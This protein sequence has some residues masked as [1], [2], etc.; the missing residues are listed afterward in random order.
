MICTG[1]FGWQWALVVRRRLMLRSLSEKF[2]LLSVSVK[3]P[4]FL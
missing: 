2:H 1:K 4:F 3:F